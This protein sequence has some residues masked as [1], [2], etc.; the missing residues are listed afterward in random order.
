V[1]HSLEH[2]LGHGNPDSQDL[3]KMGGLREKMP[4][5]CYTMWAGALALSGI[6]LF[7]GFFSKDAILYSAFHRGDGLGWVVYLLG[8][9]AAVCTAFYSWRL[10]ALTFHGK[11]RGDE[12]A[13]AHAD[14][15]PRSM[16]I[17]LLVLALGAVFAGYLLLPPAVGV[18][19]PPFQTW[20]ADVWKD[21]QAALAAGSLW[22]IPTEH[23]SIAGEWIN[24]LISS[25][26]AIG[27]SFVAYVT[28]SRPEGLE[29]VQKL[30]FE[31]R[32]ETPVMKPW[33][34]V[35]LN[36][37]YVDEIYDAVLVRPLKIASDILFVIVDV[38][39]IDLLFVNG[40]AMLVKHS[41]DLARRMQTG[42]V[43]H[44]LYAF[45]AGAVVLT[46]LFLFIVRK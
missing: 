46:A 9:A 18:H 19:H 22:R 43:R 16:A 26:I 33:Y 17:P 45:A 29:K 30:A 10:I 2:S 38:I 6:P 3:W 20:L 36:K 31:V 8:V 39:V 1:I 23:P 42:L 13:Y 21:G 14:E 40:S 34:R 25:I 12:H 7:A 24:I 28:Y 5:T 44:Y 37:Y 35:L 15:S 41:S 27:V 32:D 11:W 4:V